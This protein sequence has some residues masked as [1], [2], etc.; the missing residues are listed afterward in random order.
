MHQ[1]KREKQRRLSVYVIRRASI[2]FPILPFLSTT[3]LQPLLPSGT[4]SRGDRQLGK[5]NM[6]SLGGLIST[7]EQITSSSSLSRHILEKDT[8]QE[9]LLIMVLYSSISS[10]PQILLGQ[11]LSLANDR[12][13]PERTA[14]ISGGELPPRPRPF[15]PLPFAL[16]LLSFSLY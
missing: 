11:V 13:R 2:P 6:P 4:S 7:H 8:F 1:Y 10:D 9:I 15:H 14:V 5:K 16:N 12:T 3:P